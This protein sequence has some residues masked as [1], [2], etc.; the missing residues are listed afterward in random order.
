VESFF[1][2]IELERLYDGFELFHASFRVRTT[3]PTM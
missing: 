2:F 3:R 1:N